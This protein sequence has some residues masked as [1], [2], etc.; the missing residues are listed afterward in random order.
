[1]PCWAT[2]EIS[3]DILQESSP[4]L[5]KLGASC[6]VFGNNSFKN[7]AIFAVFSNSYAI[8]SFVNIALCSK[9][10]RI[11]LTWTKVLEH[12]WFHKFWLGNLLYSY[13]TYSR[14]NQYLYFSFY[15]PN[16]FKKCRKLNYICW[17][18]SICIQPVVNW[19]YIY[20]RKYNPLSLK[21]S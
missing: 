17:R 16:I 6:F 3:F 2:R 5:F 19:F 21:R 18:E 11:Y 4:T 13:Y 9:C 7:N 12:K 8:I 20:N 14:H 1:M 15:T 10:R